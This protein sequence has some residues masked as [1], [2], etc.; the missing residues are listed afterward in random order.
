MIAKRS[1]SLM[2]VYTILAIV[3]I[4][5]FCNIGK[6]DLYEW[7]ESRNGVNA[8][9][10]LYNHDLVNY[11]YNGTLDTWNAKPPLLI[12]SIGF[13]YSFLGYNSFALRLP[14]LLSCLLFFFFSFKII[15]KLHS[16]NV[17][18]LSCFIMLCCKA[19][20]G[21][22]VGLTADFD[23]LLLAFLTASVFYFIQWIEY[24]KENALY[25]MAWCLGLAFYAK[26]FASFVYLP[27]FV[28]YIF[29]RRNHVEYRINWKFILATVLWMS[30]IASWFMLLHFYGNH[31]QSSFYGS[32]SQTQVLVWH[33]TFERLFSSKFALAEVQPTKWI[34]FVVLDTRFNIWNYLFFIALAYFI[35]SSL[36]NKNLS[37]KSDSKRLLQLCGC[38]SFPL[39]IIITFSKNQ[40]DWYLA[41]TFIFVAI[42]IGLFIDII[43]RKR[44]IFKYLIIILF[45]F[46]FSRH[47]YY[48]FSLP[49][50]TN[51]YFSNVK[52][53]KEIHFHNDMRTPQNLNLY[54][55]WHNSATIKSINMQCVCFEKIAENQRTMQSE[56]KCFGNFCLE[57]CNKN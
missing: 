40:N 53:N 28:L 26:G 47:I 39:L 7:D 9:E 17:A 56:Q 38:F 1:I 11:Y 19:I 21:Y 57:T 52:S 20:I 35:H 13:C 44:A 15:E 33:D 23:M 10:M 12:W 42:I 24:K 5:L 25:Y 4:M 55:T 18:F 43:L 8:Y 54:A 2:N 30:I 22:H 51:Y 31:S 34:S 50:S 32:Q 16:K 29:F 45:A 37:L 3:S 49:K 27:S 46:T 41:P 6:Y 48:V 36:K 14:T